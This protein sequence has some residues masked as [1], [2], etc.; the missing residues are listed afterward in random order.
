MRLY[1]S[2]YPPDQRESIF[3][4]FLLALS[5][6]VPPGLGP[7]DLLT[8]VMDP[9]HFHPPPSYAM[10]MGR[11]PLALNRHTAVIM[12]TAPIPR[13]GCGHGPSLPWLLTTGAISFKYAYFLWV[14]KFSRVFSTS[15]FFVHSLHSSF[16]ITH[17]SI[18]PIFF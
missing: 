11:S 4:V 2:R 16:Y 9:V 10:L 18:C 15:S 13:H 1:L 5:P 8:A 12:W 7:S 6:L 3:V 17:F 14:F